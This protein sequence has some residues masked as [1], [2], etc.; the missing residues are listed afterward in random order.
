MIQILFQFWQGIYLI[1]IKNR[2]VYEDLI[3]INKYVRAV[4]EVNGD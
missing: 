2:E 1:N 4:G 3:Q